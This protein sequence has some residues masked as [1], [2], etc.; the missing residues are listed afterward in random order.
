[1]RH[2]LIC[3]A[4]VLAGCSL[5]VEPI[6]YAR[7][8]ELCADSGG[9]AWLES[10]GGNSAGFRHYQAICKDSTNVDFRVQIGKPN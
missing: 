10:T 5:A 3:I 8:Q 6:G 4:L 2:Q 1:M 9:L 7:A